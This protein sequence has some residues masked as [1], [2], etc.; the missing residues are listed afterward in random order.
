MEAMEGLPGVAIA[1]SPTRNTRWREEALRYY[2]ASIG[3]GVGSTGPPIAFEDD[4]AANAGALLTAARR[5][6][7]WGQ[8]DTE[9]TELVSMQSVGQDLNEQE[10]NVG[11]A[12]LQR[13]GDRCLRWVR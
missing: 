13:R 8:G 12:G 1:P 7:S 5:A 11:V 9:L 2:S 3:A 10:M 4:D 6:S